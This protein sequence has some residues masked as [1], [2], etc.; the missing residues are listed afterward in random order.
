MTTMNNRYIQIDGWIFEIKAVRAI[1]TDSYGKP[2]EAIANF[3]FQNDTAFID[4]LM[5]RTENDFSRTDHNTFEKFFSQIG[6]K[7]VTFERVCNEQFQSHSRDVNEVAAQP[8]LKL[9]K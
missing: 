9:V 2:Y 3:N 6:I 5:T 4:G 8:P 7:R 1:K